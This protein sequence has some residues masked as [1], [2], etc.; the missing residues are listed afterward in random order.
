VHFQLSIAT[1]KLELC[2]LGVPAT[3][4]RHFLECHVAL[5]SA[6]SLFRNEFESVQLFRARS[7]AVRSRPPTRLLSKLCPL[8]LLL[9]RGR[10]LHELL[11]MSKCMVGCS[12]VTSRS[13]CACKDVLFEP[14][15]DMFTHTERYA[16]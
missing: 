9:P 10:D 3:C 2:K 1:Y 14:G 13:D 6:L 5:L 7:P 11:R 8:S 12:A 4:S 15:W 16:T